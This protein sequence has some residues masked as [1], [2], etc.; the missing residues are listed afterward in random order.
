MTKAVGQ[1]AARTDWMV[2][3]YSKME[4]EYPIRLRV[5]SE[6]ATQIANE[7]NSGKPKYPVVARCMTDINENQ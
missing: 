7:L 1:S 2:I 6:E 5:T 4:G 3:G